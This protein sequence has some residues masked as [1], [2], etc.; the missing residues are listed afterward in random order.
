MYVCIHFMEVRAHCALFLSDSYGV[1]GHVMAEAD[2]KNVGILADVLL[3]N[4]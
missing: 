4:G 2:K 3:K 1:Y